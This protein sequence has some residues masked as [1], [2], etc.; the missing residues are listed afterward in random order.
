M[1]AV[2][3]DPLYPHSYK[4]LGLLHQGKGDKDKAK[5]CFEKY[6]VLN[7]KA[8]DGRHVKFLLKRIEKSRD[9]IQE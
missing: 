5:E 2:K 8:K 1:V 4:A 7:P 3:K 9:N 6:L